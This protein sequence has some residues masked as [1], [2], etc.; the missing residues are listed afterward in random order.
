MDKKI[1]LLEVLQDTK[2]LCNGLVMLS[3]KVC[4]GLIDSFGPD[5]FMVMKSTRQT[6]ENI[7]GFM[8]GEACGN[9]A[10]SEHEWSQAVPP[11][12]KNSVHLAKA[13]Q[14]LRPG[15]RVRRHQQETL[16]VL[17]LSDTHWDPLY[18]EGS[19]ANCDDFLCCRE[20]SG[21]VMD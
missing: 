17:H 20:E 21:E 2:M 13:A 6:P 3:P 1:H 7:C 10:I 8:F 16:T 5:V 18:K 4:N 11:P 19:L 12:S 15:S 14:L 9:P